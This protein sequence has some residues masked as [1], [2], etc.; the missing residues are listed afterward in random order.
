MNATGLTSVVPRRIFVTLNQYGPPEIEPKFF[1]ERFIKDL[2]KT[3]NSRRSTEEA[4]NYGESSSI[5][6][7][8]TVGIPVW[9]KKSG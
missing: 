2:K 8:H 1:R 7:K 5:S 4:P 9:L 3:L 6:L